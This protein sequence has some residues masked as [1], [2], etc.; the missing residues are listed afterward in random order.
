VGVLQGVG[1]AQ[2]LV[3]AHEET[4]RVTDEHLFDVLGA[5]QDFHQFG[6]PLNLSAVELGDARAGDD[7]ARIH[8]PARVEPLVAAVVVEALEHH[9]QRVHLVVTAPAFRGRGRD[10]QPFAEG[11]VLDLGHS[12]VHPDRDIGDRPAEQMGPDPLAALDRVVLEIARPRRQPRR[13]GQHPGAF[14]G[15]ELH[16]LPMRAPPPIQGQAERRLV[17]ARLVVARHQLVGLLAPVG[18]VPAPLAEAAQ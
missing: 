2:G 15:A 16:W 14:V 13:V 4:E 3:A 6:R 5:G 7:A 17:L 8:R 9:P 10:L 1:V 18:G 12:R 11:L